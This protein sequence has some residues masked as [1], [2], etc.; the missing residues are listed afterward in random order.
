[1]IGAEYFSFWQG[2]TNANNGLFSDAYLNLGTVGVFVFPFLLVLLIKIIDSVSQGIN[3]KLLI[4]P[5][6]AITIALMSTTLTTA[7]LTG[8]IIWLM[9]CLILLPKGNTKI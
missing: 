7:L 8:G 3:S 4:L 6:V 2:D 1:M 9:I 5:I